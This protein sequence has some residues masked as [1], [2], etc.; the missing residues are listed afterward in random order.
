MKQNTLAF[1][2]LK[3]F[4][5]YLSFGFNNKYTDKEVNFPKYFKRV[6]SYYRFRTLLF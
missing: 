4:I 1:I 2:K 5:I 3:F 6:Y